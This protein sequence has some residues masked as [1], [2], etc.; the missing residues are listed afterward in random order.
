[1]VEKAVNAIFALVMKPDLVCEHLLKEMAKR[2]FLSDA[3]QPVQE[4]GNNNSRYMV[5]TFQLTK[6]VM[7]IGQIAIQLLIH[8]DGIESYYKN[9]DHRVKGN[10]GAVEDLEQVTG[11]T[12]VDDEI[13]DVV[14]FVKE[15][16]ILFGRN[17]LFTLFAP[18]IVQICVNH[19]LYPVIN[20]IPMN[21]KSNN[22]Y[23]AY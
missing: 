22:M 20:L 4:D 19:K 1:V 14:N 7:I 13:T 9:R 15:K 18:L 6:F 17:G 23:C 11:G 16:E 2:M 5:S 10:N 21:S 8:L 12:T 3:V